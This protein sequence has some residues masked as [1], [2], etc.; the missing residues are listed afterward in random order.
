[1]SYVAFYAWFVFFSRV[2][3]LPVTLFQQQRTPT[4]ELLA[5]PYVQES[6]AKAFADELA[7]Q[8]EG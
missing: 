7:K 2:F 4:S 8:R 1:M 3:R 6:L 5:S